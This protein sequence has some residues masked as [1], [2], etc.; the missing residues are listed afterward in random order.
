[1]RQRGTHFELLL[2]EIHRRRL[3]HADSSL[4]KPKAQTEFE[5]GRVCGY[6]QALVEIIE[7]S[8]HLEEEDKNSE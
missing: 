3:E 2:A 5:Y 6:H 4:N 1:M 8:K 7:A